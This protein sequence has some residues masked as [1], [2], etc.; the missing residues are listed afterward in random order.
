MACVCATE[1]LV[2][3]GTVPPRAVRVSVACN[4]V[5]SAGDSVGMV[6]CIGYSHHM[7]ATQYR[8]VLGI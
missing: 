3:V 6:Q 7:L 2:E 4:I 8:L 5:R 1:A